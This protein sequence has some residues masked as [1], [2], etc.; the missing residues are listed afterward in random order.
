MRVNSASVLV[1]APTPAVFRF[2]KCVT[3]LA[4]IANGQYET[5]SASDVPHYTAVH[6]FP[7]AEPDHAYLGPPQ[8][9][10]IT[11]C[12]SCRHDV[13]RL[14][15]GVRKLMFGMSPEP[16]AQLRSEADSTSAAESTAGVCCEEIYHDHYTPVRVLHPHLNGR[17]V[18]GLVAQETYRSKLRLTR[19]S[20]RTNNLLPIERLGDSAPKYRSRLW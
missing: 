1:Q 7:S 18:S 10:V 17:P 13:Q 19:P 3:H 11:V 15:T 2:Q 16:M 12:C 5:S 14:R 8:S 9:H 6:V 4:V 20:R